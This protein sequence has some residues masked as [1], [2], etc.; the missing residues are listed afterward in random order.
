MDDFW[1]SIED[2]HKFI[3]AL[4]E[5]KRKALDDWWAS[6]KR[7]EAALEEQRNWCAHCGR[8]T[9]GRRCYACYG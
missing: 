5:W 2:A 1:K 9:G 3:E 6:V 8:R 7:D 4:P